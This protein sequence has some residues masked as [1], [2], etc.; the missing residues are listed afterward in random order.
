MRL[1]CLLGLGLHLHRMMKVVHSSLPAALGD[2]DKIQVLIGTAQCLHHRC[3]C[4]N[5]AQLQ[6]AR[7]LGVDWA[8]SMVGYKGE[9]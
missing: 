1:V 6:L 5:V 2:A 9:L 3:Q 4:V 7:I 8:Q